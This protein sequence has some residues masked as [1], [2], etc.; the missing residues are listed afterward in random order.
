MKRRVRTIQRARAAAVV[1]DIQAALNGAELLLPRTAS[2]SLRDFAFADFVF[3]IWVYRVEHQVVRV[4][5]SRATSHR[6]ISSLFISKAE[7]DLSIWDYER[8]SNRPAR[9]I[10][11][12][13]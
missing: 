7:A 6:G 3:E 2:I 5:K 12:S 9:V 11:T 13:P 10:W 1:E 8:T 4:L